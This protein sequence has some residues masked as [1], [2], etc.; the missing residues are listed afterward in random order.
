M[1]PRFQCHGRTQAD[2]RCQKFVSDPSN[3]RVIDGVYFCAAHELQRPVKHSEIDPE[4]ESKTESETESEVQTEGEVLEDDDEV[5]KD[6][7]EQES[8]PE[9]VIDDETSNL[10]HEILS[11]ATALQKDVE[12]ALGLKKKVDAQKYCE[13]AYKKRIA[14]LTDEVSRLTDA[15]E[16]LL[17][18]TDEMNAVMLQVNSTVIRDLQDQVRS[19][20]EQ[21]AVLSEVGPTP[22]TKAIAKRSSTK[23]KMSTKD[24]T[25]KYLELLTAFADTSISGAEYEARAQA[26]YRSKVNRSE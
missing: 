23:A 17:Q 12:Y 14:K 16:E 20:K 9:N 5:M 3:K 6:A 13:E 25:D 19:L 18:E 21:V 24:Y 26:L 10:V 15:Y 2:E 7:V 4:I 8:D 11:G 1:P 22:A